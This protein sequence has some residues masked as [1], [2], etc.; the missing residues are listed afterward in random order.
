[1]SRNGGHVNP[2][3]FLDYAKL[4][5]NHGK[6][7]A[8]KVIRFRLAHLSEMKKV[9][10]EEGILEET[11]L[12]VVEHCDVYYDQEL[13]DSAK[14]ALEDFRTDMPDEARDV[15]LEVHESKEDME[16]CC[17]TRRCICHLKNISRNFILHQTR[18]AALQTTAV[19]SIRIV[20]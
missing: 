6:E 10:I 20:S 1:M 5:E 13:F 11:Q 16:V 12:R 7:M 4:K 9:S 14:I 2:E 15:Q 3:L 18:L 17:V 19:Q 8:M